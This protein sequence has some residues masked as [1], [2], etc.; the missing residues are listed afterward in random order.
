MMT[1][2]VIMT[3]TLEIVHKLNDQPNDD[4]DGT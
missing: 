4:I 3:M 2:T 1:N